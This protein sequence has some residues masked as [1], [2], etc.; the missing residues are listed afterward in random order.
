M[1]E[2][3]PKKEW[4]DLS[5]QEIMDIVLNNTPVKAALAVQALLKEKNNG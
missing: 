1:M 2:N 3:A 5:V 4:V